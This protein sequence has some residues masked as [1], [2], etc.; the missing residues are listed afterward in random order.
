MPFLFTIGHSSHEME[1]FLR[2]LAMHRVDAVADV[3]SQPY[4]R[5][6]ARFSREALAEK[7]VGAGIRYAFLGRELGARREESEC[8]VGNA[9]CFDRVAA[10]PLF[11][12]GLA[13]LKKGLASYRIALLCAERDPLD[14]HR[15]IL[16]AR[17][18]ARFA[19][20]SHILPD[21]ALETHA[22]AEERLLQQ[23][24]RGETELF[25]SREHR[26]TEAYTRRAAEIAWSNDRAK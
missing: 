11:A 25:T 13:R 18:A 22:E 1:P 4:S 23:Y 5:R 7:L 3:R 12:S 9:V 16:V 8:Y 15:T 17:H 26:L 10:L 14:C 24:G 2:L 19:T 21:G 6:Y 20:V